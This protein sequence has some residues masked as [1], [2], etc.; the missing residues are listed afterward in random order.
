MIN[1]KKILGEVS[2]PSKSLYLKYEQDMKA[3]LHF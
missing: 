1:H 2:L 3:A